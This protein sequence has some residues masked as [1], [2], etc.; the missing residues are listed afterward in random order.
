[1]KLVDI[2]AQMLE[3]EKA[4]LVWAL[5]DILVG[6]GLASSKGDARRLITQGGISIKGSAGF[7]KITDPLTIF[8]E[9]E[10]IF[11]RGKRQFKKITLKI[12]RG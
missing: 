10:Y 7:E 11:K 2:V 4:G 5:P 1:M 6:V 3:D 9:G 12:E 8:H